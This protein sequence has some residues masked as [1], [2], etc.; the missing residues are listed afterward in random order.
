V[1]SV[2]GDE[3]GEEMLAGDWDSVDNPSLAIN[4]VWPREILIADRQNKANMIDRRHNTDSPHLRYEPARTPAGFGGVR[5]QFP[6]FDLAQIHALFIVHFIAPEAT[7]MPAV[8]RPEFIPVFRAE[9]LSAISVEVH[10]F[11]AKLI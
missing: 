10:C 11:V 3:W 6:T 9:E 8:M 4:L 5:N 7:Y 1:S 2:G